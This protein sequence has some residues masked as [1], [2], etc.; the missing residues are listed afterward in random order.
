MKPEDIKVGDTFTSN[1]FGRYR[2]GILDGTHAWIVFENTGNVEHP[3]LKTI[4]AN[5]VVDY[6]GPY[7]IKVGGLYNTSNYGQVR[8]IKIV[9]TKEVTVEFVD[10]GNRVETQKNVVLAGLLTDRTAIA[11]REKEA[12]ERRQEEKRI[13]R[14]TKERERLEQKQIAEAEMEARRLARENAKEQERAIKRTMNSRGEVFIGTI[15]T[16][17]LNLKFEVVGRPDG[18]PSWIVKYIESGNEYEVSEY[19]INKGSVYDKKL[20]TFFE[21]KAAYDKVQSSLWYM[22][23]RERVIQR[24]SNYQKKN[25]DRARANNQNRRARRQG[26]EGSHTIEELNILFESQEGRCAC[27]NVELT[28][29][30]KHLDHKYP[31]ALG[32]TNYIWNL[33]WLCQFCNNSKSDTHPDE[34]EIYSKSEHFQHLLKSRGATLQ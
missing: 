4:I 21:L 2:V 34:W 3:S 33:Q 28:G 19:L 10:T 31:L 32:G 1:N 22:A 6:K 30:N 20:D 11:L 15:H 9:N 23:N 25:L 16:D 18:K 12:V 29:A 8:V 13:A 5:G 26:A 7:H 27:C 14:E 24:A 17:R